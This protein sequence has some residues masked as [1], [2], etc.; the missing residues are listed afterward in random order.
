MEPFGVKFS[1]PDV[2]ITN[3][4]YLFNGLSVS[5]RAE[6]LLDGQESNFW[7]YS[8][9]YTRN[10]S[11]AGETGQPGYPAGETNTFLL[12]HETEL[13]A[14]NCEI[15]VAESYM[16]CFKDKPERSLAGIFLNESMDERVF[17][18]A[19]CI[20]NCLDLEYAYAAV[21]DRGQCFCAD[22]YSDY[23]QVSDSECS[24]V[25]NNDELEKCGG[26]WRNS[27][28]FTDSDIQSCTLGAAVESIKPHIASLKASI[29]ETAKKVLPKLERLDSKLLTY[30]F[31]RI[32]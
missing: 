4:N 20:Q 15:P 3:K 13:F 19:S 17:T 30:K 31:V 23:G 25:C 8:I 1:N 27:L 12:A 9:G 32:V 7:W 18:P 5:S 21:Q 26:K 6:T 29:D 16:G 11:Q 14:R 28:Y 2:K 24:S 22:D 10:H